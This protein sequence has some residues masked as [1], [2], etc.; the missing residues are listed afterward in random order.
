MSE[1]LKVDI[2]GL[3]L[4]YRVTGDPAAPALVLLHGL[5][6]DGSVWDGVTP[7]LSD[8][9][10]VY[11]PDLRGHGQ[12]DW[13]G[14]YS[15]ELISADV[16]GFLDALGVARATLVGHSMG[17]SAGYLLALRHPDRVAAL[18][19]AETP[20]PRPQQRPVPDRPPGPLP[21]DWPARPAIMGQ[22]NNPDPSWWERLAELTTPTLVVAGGP[23]SPFP[24]AQQ[25]A[26]A[27]RIPDSRL[28]TI[29]VGHAVPRLRPAEFAT[30]V[31]G[32]LSAGT[33]G[34]SD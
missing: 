17:G 7:L 4:A 24:E 5:T 18:V 21:Y 6:S 11:A 20:P 30:A 13:P 25:R 26:M 8:R 27:D 1:L 33:A 16:L 15:L 3:T 29:P 19:L 9:W 31:A 22:V 12:S 10:R 14:S 2:G 34:T 23:E 28:V 32:F